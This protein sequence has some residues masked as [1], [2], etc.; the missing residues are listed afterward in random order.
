MKIDLPFSDI[1]DATIRER[2]EIALGKTPKSEV[3]EINLAG[4][5]ITDLSWLVEYPN[6]RKLELGNT[7]ISDIAVLQKFPIVQKLEELY[8]TSTEVQDISPI[9]ECTKLKKLSLFGLEIR[10]LSPLRDM[11]IEQLDLS[12]T[13]FID[14]TTI[15][16][17]QNLKELLLIN[18]DV[19]VDSLLKLKGLPFLEKLEV[20][21]EYFTVQQEI[22]FYIQQKQLA[23]TKQIQQKLPKAVTELL[24]TSLCSIIDSLRELPERQQRLIFSILQDK[25]FS[26]A[27]D[28]SV[29]VRL[30]RVFYDIDD[31][32]NSIAPTLTILYCALHPESWENLEMRE[33]KRCLIDRTVEI[34]GMKESKEGE[35]ELKQELASKQLTFSEAI[36][37]MY[38]FTCCKLQKDFATLHLEENE[39]QERMGIIAGVVEQ[40]SLAEEGRV[41]Y[42]EG[43][44]KTH[45]E[46]VDM[47]PKAERRERAHTAPT[48][49]KHTQKFN[50]KNWDSL[51]KKDPIWPEIFALIVYTSSSAAARQRDESK[52]LEIVKAIFCKDLTGCPWR[53]LPQACPHWRQVY[54]YYKL[55]ER[56]GTLD[57]I[58]TI[59]YSEPLLL[60]V[61]QM[62]QPIDKTQTEGELRMSA[63]QR[64][65]AL[66]RQGFF[67]PSSSSG[68]AAST[69]L[70]SSFAAS[71]P[72]SSSS[73]SR[74]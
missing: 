39:A 27:E 67:V 9:K 48:P 55:W 54:Y 37:Y 49:I 26:S 8:L 58:R 21:Q 23:T 42:D 15:L 69:S 13:Q 11:T 38:D 56:N 50:A 51:S 7:T 18:V 74:S 10:D 65:M 5:D 30:R 62:M 43:F 47:Y 29:I 22:L 34:Y 64:Q 71:F 19:A 53:Y 68:S 61:Q 28:R 32:R 31:S 36:G 25:Q 24:E 2:L 14:F 4:N 16:S 41:S 52:M 73:S 44:I 45:N 3:T 63:L 57:Q 40:M 59:S 70:N 12:N 66:Q 60:P 72:S 20:D 35:K 46:F 33:Y 1:V 6:V 17:L